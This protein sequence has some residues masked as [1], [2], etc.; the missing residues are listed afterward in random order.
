MS[1]GKVAKGLCWPMFAVNTCFLDDAS[2]YTIDHDDVINWKHFPHHWPFVREI[3]RSPV[4]SPHKGQWRGAFMFSLICALNRRLS[5][6]S[7]GW[8]FETS[9]CSLWRHC[10][11]L[12]HRTHSCAI[13]RLD[14]LQTPT[15][16]LLAKS[17]CL[18][19][20][21]TRRFTSVWHI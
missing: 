5:K 16:I 8:W 2:N 18:Q 15:G 10:N 14:N 4:N 11:A 21:C 7:W 20:L 13:S 17:E 12:I 19:C 6:Q 1:K 3:H 9:S